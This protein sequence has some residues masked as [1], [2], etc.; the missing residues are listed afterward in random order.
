MLFVNTSAP[1]S[2]KIVFQW[3]RFSYA[4]MRGLTNILKQ[5]GYLVLNTRLARFIP[6]VQIL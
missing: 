3:L 6:E 2:G 4:R 5:R 1:V